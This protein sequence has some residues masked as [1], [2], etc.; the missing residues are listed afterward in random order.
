M[1]RRTWHTTATAAEHSGYHADTVRK[2]LEAGEM[3]GTQRVPGGRWR[4]HVDCLDAWTGGQKCPHGLGKK[5]A[6]KSAA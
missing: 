5:P 3:H 4:V 6:K 1:S 2:A